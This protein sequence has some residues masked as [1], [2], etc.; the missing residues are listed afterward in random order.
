MIYK[1]KNRRIYF[2]MIMI[3]VYWG[4]LIFFYFIGAKMRIYGEKFSFLGRAMMMSVYMLVLVMGIKMGIDRQVTSNL[5]VIGVSSFMITAGAVGGSILFISVARRF[6]SLDRFG[7]RVRDLSEYREEE[8]ERE[9]N[10]AN[11]KS[12]VIIVVLVLLGLVSGKFVIADSMQEMI[13]VVTIFTGNLLTI[14][15]CILIAIIGFDMGIA[16]TVAANV[17]KVGLRVFVFPLAIIS[18]TLLAGTAVTLLFGFSLREGLAICSGFGWYSYAPA[19]ISAAG[20]QF[21]VAGAV[22]FMHNVMRET[23]GIIFIPIVAKRLGYIE[24]LALPGIGT[25]DVCMPI[26]DRACRE[27]TVVYGFVSGFIICIFTSVCVPLIMAI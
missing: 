14:L 25:M 18:G 3:F 5:G 15:L 23:I 13:R 7:N 1:V 21:A 22:A 24:A 11:M 9:K 16:G 4:I 12:T 10:T 6:M 20:Q 26:V 2:F 27:D 19:V 17:K 8:K